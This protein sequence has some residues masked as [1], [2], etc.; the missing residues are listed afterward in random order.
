MPQISRILDQKAAEFSACHPGLDS[1]TPRQKSLTLNRWVRSQ[2]LVGLENPERDYR[3]LRNCLIGQALLQEDHDSIPIISC[4]IF[5]CI[6][7]RIGLDAHCCNFPGHIHAVVLAPRGRTLD[8]EP[9]SP[10]H[11]LDRMYLDPFGNDDE[12]P[13]ARLEA[14]LR[15]FNASQDP[16]S[17]LA[18]ASSA[19]VLNR[20]TTNITATYATVL[21][22][23]EQDAAP[24]TRLS[25]SNGSMNLITCIY[26]SM[27]GALMLTPPE[28]WAELDFFLGRFARSW[29]EDAW[30]IEKYL[31]PRAP[32]RR[33]VFGRHAGQSGDAWEV[34]RTSQRS[35]ELPPPVFRRTEGSNDSVPYKI[36]QVFRHRRYGYLGA[37]TGWSDQSTRN[38]SQQRSDGADAAREEASDTDVINRL[39]MDRKTYFTHMCVTALYYLLWTTHADQGPGDLPHPNAT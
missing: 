19:A 8:E 13:L 29:P 31:V 3:N 35:D 34:L 4:A 10:D 5:T 25:H 9:V 18:P 2:N 14:L 16:E 22:R 17:S 27:W 24:L 39:R 11:P 36:G 15:R 6:A 1:Q 28:T 38:Q 23:P 33:I 32:H 12:I 30:L 21:E 37:I 26:A 20:T 7:R